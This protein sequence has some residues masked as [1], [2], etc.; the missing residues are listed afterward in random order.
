MSVAT[1]ERVRSV[2]LAFDFVILV[3]GAVLLLPRAGSAVIAL[4]YSAAVVLATWK[5]GWRGGASAMLLAIA[6]VVIAFHTIAAPDAAAFV[7][8]SLVVCGVARVRELPPRVV[9]EST[10]PAV[11][12]PL[13]PVVKLTAKKLRRPRVLMLEKRRGTA[14]TIVHLVRQ[15]GVEIEVVERWIDAVDEL[16]RFAPDAFF[17]DCEHL[18]FEKMYRLLSEHASKMPIILTAKQNASIPDVPHA[19]SVFRPYDAATILR[20][21]RQ[22]APEQ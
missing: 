20:I 11:A 15:Q 16:F 5:G 10:S 21:A 12:I 3:T 22:V 4:A 13:A 17:L 9:E 6:A 1:R 8:T 19:E 14:N 7:A 2:A 18:E